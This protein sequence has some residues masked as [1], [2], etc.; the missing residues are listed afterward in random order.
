MYNRRQQD[1]IDISQNGT[2]LYS[3]MRHHLMS[4]NLSPWCS[5]QWPRHFLIA[6]VQHLHAPYTAWT[7]WRCR[8]Y[9]RWLWCTIPSPF[10]T[11]RPDNL[12]ILSTNRYPVC[13]RNY[14]IWLIQNRE[15]RLYNSS[16]CTGI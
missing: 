15:L 2:E 13:P 4:Y 5:R 14:S 9:N 3:R 8:L 12:T 1:H 10:Y 16:G 7:E 11:P 6:C